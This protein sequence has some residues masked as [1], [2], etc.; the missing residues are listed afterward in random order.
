MSDQNTYIITKED[1]EVILNVVRRLPWD[2]ANI[3]MARVKDLPLVKIKK[4]NEN[5]EELF[6]N[7]FSGTGDRNEKEKPKE[8]LPSTASGGPPRSGDGTPVY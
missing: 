3:V 4:E 5:Q 1:L 8:V 2:D 7:K 6:K